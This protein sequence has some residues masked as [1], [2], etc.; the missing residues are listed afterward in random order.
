[1]GLSI[2]NHPAIGVYHIYIYMYVYIYIHRYIYIIYHIYPILCLPE[3]RRKIFG[4]LRS[5]RSLR[6]M[7]L[8]AASLVRSP[9]SERAKLLELLCNLYQIALYMGL[10][11][12]S[13]PLNPMVND[14]YPY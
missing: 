6:S 9:G 12:N 8:G 14:H 7:V 2:I 4:S 10:S 5:F 3:L 11:E 13:I 1:M